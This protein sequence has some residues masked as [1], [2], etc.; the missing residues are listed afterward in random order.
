MSDPDD[1]PLLKY[2]SPLAG[3][4]IAIIVSMML[5]ATIAGQLEGDYRTRAVVYT[6]AVL[7]VL[8]GGAVMFLLAYRGERGRLSVGRV[9]L[10]TISIWLWPLFLVLR[11]RPAEKD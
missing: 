8:A 1:D 9:L 2:G 10:W 6:A 5:A 7:W 3:V 4:L 11:R